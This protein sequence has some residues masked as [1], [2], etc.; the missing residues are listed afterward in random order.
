MLSVLIVCKEIDESLLRTVKS[1]EKLSPQYIIDVSD[2]KEALGVRK[3]QL[4][5]LA[6][7]EWVLV[8]DSDEE[9]SASL[10][11]EIKDAVT[12]SSP[13][14]TGYSLPYQPYMLGKQLH[15]GGEQYA[16]IQLFRKSAGQFT[17]VPVHEHPLVAGKI[18]SLT[19]VVR[20]YTYGSIGSMIAKF[21]KYAW[22]MAGEKRRARE[23]ATVKKLFLYEPHMVWARVVLDEA[24]K[25]GWRGIL[26]AEL[27][28]YMEGLTYWLLLVRT[29]FRV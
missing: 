27:F 13:D 11:E 5:K 16:R 10:C 2:T 28:G 9:V 15:Y 6:H 8:L 4:I 1:I 12:Y 21:S 23:R 22:Q 17:P 24:W 26:L 25:D 14:V 18:A 3:N 7:Y 19:G 29:V 20:H